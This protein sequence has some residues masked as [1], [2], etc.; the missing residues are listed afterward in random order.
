M[1][2]YEFFTGVYYGKNTIY[3]AMVSYHSSPWYTMVP[4]EYR[5]MV[6]YVVHDGDTML[7]PWYT[8]VIAL[9]SM[10]LNRLTWYEGGMPW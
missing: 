5:T 7:L 6:K 1:V 8:M 4:S 9:S 10:V 3:C 2:N